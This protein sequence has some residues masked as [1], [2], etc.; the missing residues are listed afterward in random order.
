M[1]KT[2]I[3]GNTKMAELNHF[4]LTH[5]SPHEVAAFTVDSAFIKEEAIFGL[6]VVPFEEV[7]SL[8]PPS[9]YK[10]RIAIFYAKINKLRAEKYYQ[11]KAKGYELINYISS[12]ATTWPGLIIGD[13]CFI[14]EK[15]VCAPSAVIGSNVNMLTNCT[16]GP[17]T[18]IKDHCYLAPHSSISG[19][20]TIEEYCFIGANATIMDNLTVA[21]ECVIGAGALILEN[22]RAKGV[23]GG[24]PA[25]PLPLNIDRLKRI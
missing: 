5:D 9:D 18:I 12:K 14:G 16:I 2:V 20:T 25:I 17:H 11:A 8:Y 6:P 13:N 7:E 15:C 19:W 3:F 23:Y 22:T 21:Q 10:M 24:N 1:A 4:Y